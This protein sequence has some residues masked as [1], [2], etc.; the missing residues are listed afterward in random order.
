MQRLLKY[1]ILPYVEI[2]KAKYF[3][4]VEM[5]IRKFLKIRI[6]YIYSVP[7]HTLTALFHKMGTK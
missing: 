2:H 6:I 5:Q 7:F 3:Y 1:L 4:C